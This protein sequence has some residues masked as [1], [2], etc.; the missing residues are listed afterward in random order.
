M[1]L[2][3]DPDA[4]GKLRPP[5]RQRL[6]A[7]SASARDGECAGGPT[8]EQKRALAAQ[9]PAAMATTSTQKRR[10]AVRGTRRVK[11]RLRERPR[12]S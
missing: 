4:D 8:G 12:R 10:R 6:R 1:M 9:A 5:R 7:A 2:A 3:R 11:M